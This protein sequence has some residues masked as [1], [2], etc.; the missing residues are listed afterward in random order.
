[1][2]VGYFYVLEGGHVEGGGWWRANHLERVVI[3]F[4]ANAELMV[5][6][7][8]HFCRC[9]VIEKTVAV[10]QLNEI[11]MCSDDGDCVVL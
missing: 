11:V 7:L 5:R 3:S 6:T 10:Y 1:M 8:V 2:L 4:G 9:F